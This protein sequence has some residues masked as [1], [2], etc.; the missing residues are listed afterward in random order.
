MRQFSDIAVYGP[1]G[2]LALIVE[3][4]KKV[5][6]STSWAAMM[7]RNLAAHGQFSEAQTDHF[8]N[9]LKL[10]KIGFSWG[11]SHSLCVPYRISTMRQHWSEK[12]TLVRFN[13]GLE[14]GD[15]LIADIEQAM[16]AMK[17]IE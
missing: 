15:D 13:I 2:N 14:D 8:V 4:K 11:G 17:E 1:D 12:G 16:Q 7:R 9:S 6:T 10:F 5:S 3:V